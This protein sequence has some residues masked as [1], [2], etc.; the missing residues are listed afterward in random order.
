MYKRKRIWTT[1][2]K[3]LVWVFVLYL[4][5]P[6][7]WGETTVEAKNSA[8]AGVQAQVSMENTEDV[9]GM[10]E[11]QTE[12][13]QTTAPAEA[14]LY[15]KAAV[16]MDAAS[17]RVLY[18]KNG[19]EILPMAS[20]TKIMTCIVALENAGLDELVE[21][22]DYAASMPKVK[23]YVKKGE[24]YHL[25]DLLYS[26]MLESHN[27]V[28]V[29][30][31]EHIGKQF[32]DKELQEKSV[33]DYTKEESMLAVAAFA[34]LM[35]EKAAELQC[36]NTWFITPNGL[37]ATETF[38]GTNAT[39]GMEAGNTTTD[40]GIGE[41]TRQHSTTAEELARIMSYCV[42][43]SPQ[44]DKFLEITQTPSY[45]VTSLTGRN[46]F[47]S[48]HNAFLNMMDGAISGKTGFTNLAGYCYVGA[49]EHDGNTYVVALLACGWPNNKS[50]KWSDMKKLAQYGMEEYAY[51][52]F[53][54][55]SEYITFPDKVLV[56]NGQTEYIG[57]RAYVPVA[58]VEGGDGF[59][60]MNN[61][62]GSGE[63]TIATLAGVQVKLPFGEPDGLLMREDEE[64]VINY[65]MEE[66]LDAPVHKG[67]IIGVITYEV[68]GLIYKQEDIVVTA[69][70]MEIDW[71]WCLEK[72]VQ[73]YL[74]P[75][76]HDKKT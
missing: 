23:M 1:C 47:C 33:A 36:E 40:S 63:A 30:I 44:K 57:Q 52:E 14:R 38:R 4:L 21:I 54:E 34:D 46:S 49:V 75:T 64:V 29:A 17:G 42:L 73:G 37:D 31:A 16:L 5:L 9:E 61:V 39:E 55:A 11:I 43:H 62:T 70:V 22:S 69:D 56:R 18:E 45:T 76:A 41:Y 3:I 28:A 19:Q 74:T 2:K 7:G 15:A 35:N 67:D 8:L 13:L 72:V 26:L 60:Q 48:N 58:V 51:R 68:D 20:T 25:G 50:Y 27:D 6:L 10:M 71:K 65:R 53:G 32:L 24:S 66:V 12:L 59:G